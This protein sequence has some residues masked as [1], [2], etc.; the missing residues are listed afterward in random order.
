M[1]RGLTLAAL[2][3]AAILNVQVRQRPVNMG[4]DLLARLCGTKDAD[5][6][7]GRAIFALGGLRTEEQ[8]V[9]GGGL[10]LVVVDAIEAEAKGER[11]IHWGR[12]NWRGL[13]DASLCQLGGG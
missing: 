8:R 12:R 7:H 13:S 5:D 6:G 4:A 10:G 3:A 2:Q 9:K 1:R 11:V